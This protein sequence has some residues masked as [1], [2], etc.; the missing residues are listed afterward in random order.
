MDIFLEESWNFGPYERLETSNVLRFFRRI[1]DHG[2]PAVGFLRF[3]LEEFL[4]NHGPPAVGF[5]RLFLEEL[6]DLAAWII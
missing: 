6:L 3:F 2:T 4:R 5:L 1:M